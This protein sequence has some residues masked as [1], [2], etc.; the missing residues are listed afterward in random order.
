MGRITVIKVTASKKAVQVVSEPEKGT[1]K[2]CGKETMSEGNTVYQTSVMFLKTL[3]EGGNPKNVI[4]LNRMPEPSSQKFKP[5]DPYGYNPSTKVDT[6]GL[7][8]YKP[9]EEKPKYDF[10]D[11]DVF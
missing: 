7:G 6:S 4:W 3:L 1:C 8:A 9:K 11:K 5:S 2:H 10:S